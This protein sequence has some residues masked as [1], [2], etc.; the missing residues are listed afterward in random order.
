MNYLE[1]LNQQIQVVD[2]KIDKA[3]KQLE[4]GTLK[5]KVDAARELSALEAR[6]H[7]LSDRLKQASTQHAEDW[8]QL[9]ATF[10]EDLDSLS[11]ALERWITQFTR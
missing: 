11:D 3:K 1:N 5:D 7:E 4:E 9:H 6:R 2:H 10:K 8:S